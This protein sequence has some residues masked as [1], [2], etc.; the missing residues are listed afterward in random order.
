MTYPNSH[1][2]SSWKFSI[3]WVLTSIYNLDKLKKTL[4]KGGFTKLNQNEASNLSQIRPHQVWFVI[5]S[6]HNIQK[7]QSSPIHPIQA[8]NR[9]GNGNLT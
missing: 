6:S 8:K 2:P 9:N 5:C 7:L 3:P 1:N 4:N